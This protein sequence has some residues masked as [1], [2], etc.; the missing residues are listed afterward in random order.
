MKKSLII[1]IIV[2]LVI[3]GIVFVV[4]SKSKDNSVSAE[5]NG[6][7]E[8]FNAQFEGKEGTLRG[9]TVLTLIQTVQTSN[10]EN[11]Q[12]IEVTGDLGE[13]AEDVLNNIERLARYE[14]SIS[15][16]EK[17]GYINKII[18]KKVSMNNSNEILD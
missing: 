2:I 1:I 8:N 7:C 3:I 10:K 5:D 11:K 6:A 4:L 18:V 16:D 14:V 9:T 13:N 12:Q 15:K 17:T